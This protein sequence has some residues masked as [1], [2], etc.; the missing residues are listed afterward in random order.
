VDGWKY[1]GT[2]KS[3][4]GFDVSELAWGI[5]GV[6]LGI[7]GGGWALH[8]NKGIWILTKYTEY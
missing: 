7:W 3:G 6:E 8:N 1:N 5:T 2:P 4:T